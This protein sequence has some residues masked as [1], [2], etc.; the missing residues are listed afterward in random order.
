M[1]RNHP[2][3]VFGAH[4]KAEQRAEAH[5]R[6]RADEVQSRYRSLEGGIQPWSTLKAL[7]R[8]AQLRMKEVKAFDINDIATARDDVVDDERALASD[9]L[10][11]AAEATRGWLPR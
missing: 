8:A 2:R 11:Y 9:P 5:G 10:Q 1:R 7:D 4:H 3:S 6:G